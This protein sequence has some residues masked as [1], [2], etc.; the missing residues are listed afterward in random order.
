MRVITGSARGRR[1]ETLPGED[2][3]RP[4]AQRVK[5]GLFSA[6]QFKIE[7]ARVLDLFAGSG[8]LGI[9]ALSRG[10]RACVFVDESRQAAAVVARNLRHTGLEGRARVTVSGAERFLQHQREAFDVVFV[11]PPYR[12]GT[13]QKMLGL[14]SDLVAEGGTVLCETERK[15]AMPD[16]CGRLALK[17]S[18]RYGRTTVWMYTRSVEDA[19]EDSDG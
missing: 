10:A 9:E 15:C 16:G 14:L 1:L 17:R 2:V 8:Q 13:A 3:V 12:Q 18:Y 7:G 19:G 11:D 6:I 4:T 5:E